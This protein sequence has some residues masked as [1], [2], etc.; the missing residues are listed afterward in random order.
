MDTV[1]ACEKNSYEADYL[2]ALLVTQ[3]QIVLNPYLV[4]H[5][6][7]N[8]FKQAREASALNGSKVFFERMRE[9]L[10]LVL[11]LLN[12][13]GLS[14]QDFMQC[15]NEKLFVYSPDMI[16]SEIKEAV[17]KGLCMDGHDGLHLKMWLQLTYDVS[18]IVLLVN[19]FFR[20]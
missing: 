11:S 6:R 3:Y 13:Q 10:P 8:A 7:K 5:N 1:F 17:D 14:L 15:M 18:L 4:H 20:I 12:E 2:I 19:P 16:S 9:T